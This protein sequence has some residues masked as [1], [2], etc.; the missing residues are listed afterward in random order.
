MKIDSITIK[1]FRCFGSTSTT[2]EFSDEITAFVGANGSGKTA[3]LEA[4]LRVFG[5]TT[6]QR[7]VV[8][9]DF[10]VSSD[11]LDNN[12]SCRELYID[13]RLTFS[14]VLDNNTPKDPA[15]PS[16]FRYMV[17]D[18]PNATPF[19]RIRLEAKWIDDGTIDGDI[20]QK[21]WWVL[22]SNESPQNEDKVPCE[23]S[24]RGLIQV[25]YVPAIRD[26]SSQ[27]TMSAGAMLGRL[28]RSVAWSSETQQCIQDASAQIYQA[29]GRE[30]AISEINQTLASKWKELHNDVFDAEPEFNIANR[31]FEEIIRNLNVVFRP[32]EFESERE[33]DALSDGQ[34]SL[35]YFSL[36]ASVFEVERK[37]LSSSSIT[38]KN[39]G[40]DAEDENKPTTIG[41]NLRRFPIPVLIIFA[42]EEPENHLSP[43]FLS[44]IIKQIRFLV[45]KQ[46]AQAVITSH[47]PAI[48]GRIK[49][50]E[51]RH[52]RLDMQSRTTII[53]KINFVEGENNT[54]RAKYVREAVNAYPELYFARFVILGEG[55]SEQVILPKLALAMGLD[56]DPAF[57][58][59]VPLGGR[60]VNYFWRL[61]NDLHIPHATLLDLD[62]GRKGG[63]WGRIKYALQQLLAIGVS[64]EKLLKFTD[65]QGQQWNFT[66]QEIKQLHGRTEKIH[67]DH[68]ILKHLE[69]FG[70]FFS[71]PLDIDIAMLTR[72]FDVYKATVPEERG[73]KIPPKED[74]LKYQTYI[75]QAIE[76]VVGDDVDISI[77][78]EDTQE[79]FPWYRYLFL[80]NSKPSTHLQALSEIT[81]EDLST[82]SPTELKNILTYVNYKLGTT[83][84]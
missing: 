38:N 57:V 53:K 1:G 15:I 16:C 52:F 26:P 45:T 69:K 75:N 79:L 25:H 64:S 18:Q 47:S 56:V 32:T 58:A 44:R 21:L 12:P 3:L 51:V 60:H 19:V 2:I 78:T 22:T 67:I 31:K 6:K 9:T 27:L 23:A 63:G 35:F 62:Y 82:E 70:V 61:L 83:Q 54:T 20:E 84:A 66:E 4:I 77:Y 37:I 5:I 17:V 65:E 74:T 41:F 43:Y 55:D 81:D 34:K 71:Y 46:S 36:V 80:I 39:N 68:P 48:L 7:T 33:L 50:E 11:I 49:P 40:G 8:R 28:L 42:F 72:F 29:F 13:V 24:D 30:A 10:Y 14:E 73:P 59:I 76:T